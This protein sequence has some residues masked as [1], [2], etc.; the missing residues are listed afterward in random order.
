MEASFLLLTPVVLESE[1]Q[2]ISMPECSNPARNSSPITVEPPT[3]TSH[4][5]N[6]PSVP[7]LYLFPC[8]RH[9]VLHWSPG[10]EKEASD[11]WEYSK[12]KPPSLMEIHQHQNPTLQLKTICGTQWLTSSFWLLSS[13]SKQRRHHTPNEQPELRTFRGS[14][15]ST[16]DRIQLEI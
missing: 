6:T 15:R 13:S 2:D 16:T 4:S 1:I 8:P 5:P 7:S 10:R 12:R 9:G 14:H 11:W 3:E